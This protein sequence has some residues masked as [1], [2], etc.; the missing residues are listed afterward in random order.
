[1]VYKI[2]LNNSNELMANT[3][4]KMFDGKK[5]LIDGNHQLVDFRMQE[6]TIN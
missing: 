1:M 6:T 3:Y 5:L 4:T 2:K